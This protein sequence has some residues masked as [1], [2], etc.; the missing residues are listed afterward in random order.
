[1][2][3][4]FTAL[5]EHN[6]DVV[7][8][9]GYVNATNTMIENA[10]KTKKFNKDIRVIVG[11]VHA[12]MNYTAFYDEDIDFI[13]HSGGFQTFRSLVQKNMSPSECREEKGICAKDDKGVW[14]CNDP[15]TLD[16]N[17]FIVPDRSHFYQHKDKF[18]YLHYG[19]CAMVKS[20]SCP[21]Q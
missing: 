10:R 8:I 6:P 9:T 2:N 15:R 18:T 16:M 20:G 13:V 12:E 14:K 5:I 21:E 7:G 17:E 3:I 19:P 1:M 11:G 4:E